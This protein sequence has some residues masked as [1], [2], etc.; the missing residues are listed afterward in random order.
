MKETCARL[1]NRLETVKCGALWVM[2]RLDVGG[3]VLPLKL[4][5]GK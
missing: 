3:P 5:I 1:V 2:F 4:V